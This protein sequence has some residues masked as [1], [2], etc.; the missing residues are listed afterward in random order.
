M[1]RNPL[2]DYDL[3]RLEASLRDLDTVREAIERYRK[4]IRSHWWWILVG[5]ALLFALLMLSEKDDFKIVLISGAMII[6]WLI[7]QLRME[8]CLR[9]LLL[10]KLD[11]EEREA[12][13]GHDAPN[14]EDLSDS[15]PAHRT[16]DPPPEAKEAS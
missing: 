5:A 16:N 12:I 6:G 8:S 15:K 10:R 4:H 1:G 13:R 14:G 3:T 7:H 11:L 9:A 2:T